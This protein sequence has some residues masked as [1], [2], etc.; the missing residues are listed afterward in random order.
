MMVNITWR[1]LQTRAG[2]RGRLGD[3]VLRTVVWSVPGV[4]DSAAQHQ[5]FIL[6]LFWYELNGAKRYI[7]TYK[8]VAE[9]LQ[10]DEGIEVG[11][12]NCISEP[13]IC[14]NW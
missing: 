7:P 13:V 10:H 6:V 2:A 8:A 1:V 11:S 3:R 9:A 4:R 5:H 12:V 14:Q